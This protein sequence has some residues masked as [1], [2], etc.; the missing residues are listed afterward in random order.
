MSA[1]DLFILGNATCVVS[2]ITLAAL[3]RCNLSGLAAEIYARLI[4]LQKELR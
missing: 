2:L 4:A 3:W 1:L